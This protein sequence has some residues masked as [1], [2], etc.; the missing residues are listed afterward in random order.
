[1]SLE[2]DILM[3]DE[4]FGA[5]DEQSRILLGEELTEIWLRTKRTIIFVTHSLTEAAFLSDEIVLMSSRPGRISKI[6]KVDV[7]RPRNPESLELVEIRRE[8][9]S[10]ISAESKKRLN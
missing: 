10:H 4:P 2:T 7:R 6:I 1:L 9:W 3:M 8:L 5:L